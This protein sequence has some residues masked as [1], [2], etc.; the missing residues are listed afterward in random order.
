MVT[1]IVRALLI[2]FFC[3]AAQADST[4]SGK[5]IEKMNFTNLSGSV[6]VSFTRIGTLVVG[7]CKV[8]DVIGFRAQIAA[9]K[10]EHVDFASLDFSS[11]ELSSA[12]FNSSVLRKASFRN[13]DLRNAT[14]AN[15]EISNCSFDRADLRGATFTAVSFNNCSFWGAF[16]DDRT[17]L[18]F[19][20]NEAVAKGMTYAP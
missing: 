4:F 1:F 2:T 9:L 5:S 7:P 15:M 6:D 19:D 16:Y 20:A 18:P 8:T 12:V 13:T 11:A 3:M 10:V 17:Q 14:F